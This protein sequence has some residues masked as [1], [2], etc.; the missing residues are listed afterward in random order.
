[1]FIRGSFLLYAFRTAADPF[2]VF[3]QKWG[4]EIIDNREQGLTLRS[5]LMLSGFAADPF[6]GFESGV[7]IGKPV[8]NRE[9]GL[10]LRS[11]DPAKPLR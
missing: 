11:R 2:P 6:L 4:S 7:R 10:T 3:N 1:M 5:R 8:G 9:Q